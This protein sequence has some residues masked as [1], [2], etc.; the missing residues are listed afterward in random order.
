MRWFCDTWAYGDRNLLCILSEKTAAFFQLHSV[1]YQL[2]SYN[3]FLKSFQ[4]CEP[5]YLTTVY[6]SLWESIVTPAALLC[7]VPKVLIVQL[8]EVTAVKLCEECSWL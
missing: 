2:I 8:P 6:L 3:P 4:S 5:S 7:F 1:C